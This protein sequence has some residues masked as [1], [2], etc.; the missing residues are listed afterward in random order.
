M[1]PHPSGSN[2]R[3][4]GLLRTSGIRPYQAASITPRIMGTLTSNEF[5][6]TVLLRLHISEFA[7]LH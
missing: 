1:M 7:T 6:G 5:L 2:V 3:A 4:A